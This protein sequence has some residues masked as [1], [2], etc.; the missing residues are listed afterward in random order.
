MSEV[1]I[2]ASLSSIKKTDR[3]NLKN[4]FSVAWRLLLQTLSYYNKLRYLSI[5]AVITFSGPS[6]NPE[7]IRSE[8]NEAAVGVGVSRFTASRLL[9]LPS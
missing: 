8:S 4:E 9:R 3:T 7:Q 5:F 2:W 1:S 6:G